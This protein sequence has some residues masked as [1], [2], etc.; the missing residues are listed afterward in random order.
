MTGTKPENL[1]RPES[2][3]FSD[4]TVS[5]LIRYTDDLFSVDVN[6]KMDLV[7]EDGTVKQDVIEKSLF[8]TEKANGRWMCTNMTSEDL[9]DEVT[10]VRV[11]F[12]QDG[13]VLSSRMINQKDEFIYCPDAEIPAELPDNTPGHSMK[14]NDS[15]QLEQISFVGWGLLLEDKYGKPYYQPVFEADLDRKAM[16]PGGLLEEPVTLYPI[17]V[18]EKVK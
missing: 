15:S 11:R 7:R 6:L 9:F 5:S 1:Q 8:F 17:F 14:K 13:N 10:T 18:W 12:V 3:A 16:I 2:Y 4:E